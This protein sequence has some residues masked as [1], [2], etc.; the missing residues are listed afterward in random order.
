[1]WRIYIKVQILPYG[2]HNNYEVH[3]GK[4]ALFKK[5]FFVRNFEFIYF[6][7]RVIRDQQCKFKANDAYREDK[8]WICHGNV[9]RQLKRFTSLQGC[10]AASVGYWRLIPEGWRANLHCESVK[11]H[12]TGSFT[13]GSKSLI[14][15]ENVT[16]DEMC[17]YSA[18]N[19]ANFGPRNNILT[20]N[21]QFFPESSNFG[22][23]IWRKEGALN[24]FLFAVLAT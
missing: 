16:I 22:C 17:I 9:D 15:S 6:K 5:R 13:E 2:E 4:L 8:H 14:N 24:F 1:M 19:Y 12:G 10:G 21:L 20:P 18:E 7:P 23:N 3:W 11:T